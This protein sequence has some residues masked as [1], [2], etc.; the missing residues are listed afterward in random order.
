MNILNSFDFFKDNTTVGESKILTN[1][2][3]GSQLILQVDG[4]NTGIGLSVWGS[5]TD[6]NKWYKLGIIDMLTFS[7][8]NSI[9]KNGI[10]MI[11]VDGISKI[12]ISLTSITS[13]DISVHGKLGY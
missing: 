13:G 2:N 1:A 4:T 12:K 5:L 8:L 3:T 9:S 11:A 6:L 10:Y 7:S